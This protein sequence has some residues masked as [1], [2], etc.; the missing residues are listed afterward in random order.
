[1]VLQVSVGSPSG[2]TEGKATSKCD[3]AVGAYCLLYTHDLHS[4]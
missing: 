4:H 2:S 1:M 3:T